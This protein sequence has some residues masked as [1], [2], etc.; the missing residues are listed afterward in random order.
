MKILNRFT[1]SVLFETSAETLFRADLSGADLSGA[2]LSGA[3][4]SGANLSGAD[5]FRADLSGAK[6][7]DVSKLDGLRSN[8]FSQVCATPE[9]LNM[10]S[11]HS[12]CGT[13]HC[14]AGW[15]VTIHP[16]G[17]LL[18][19][20]FGTNAAAALIFHVCEGEVPDFYGSNEEAMEWL[21]KEK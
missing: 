8:I 18:E 1:K 17:K 6:I 21:K 20:I 2:D 10:K 3:D 7:P 16:E 4:L 15:A 13:T 9:N 11:W 5:L 19:S 14:L 12:H